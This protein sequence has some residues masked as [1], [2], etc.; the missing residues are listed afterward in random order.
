MAVGATGASAVNSFDLSKAETAKPWSVSVSLRGLYDSNPYNIPDGN[1]DKKDSF[2]LWVRPVLGLNLVKEEIFLGARYTYDA[3]Y[4]ERYS[5]T[6]QSHEIEGIV[7]YKPSERVRVSARD[8]FAYSQQPE[9]LQG[10][11]AQSTFARTD[12]SGFRNRAEFNGNVMFTR[13]SGMGFGYFGTIYDYDASGAPTAGFTPYSALLDRNENLFNVN[14]RQVIVPTWIGYLG[15]QYGFVDYTG[16][17]QIY[18]GGPKSDSRNYRSHYV[19]AGVDHDISSKLIASV[20]GGATYTS[21]PSYSQEDGWMPYGTVSL[22]YTYLPGCTAELG[23][24]NTMSA[25]DV[26]AASAPGPGGTTTPT[27]SQE[28]SSLYLSVEHR[29]TRDISAKL[30]SQMQ[31]ASFVG[32]AYAD[33]NENWLW[34]APSLEYRFEAGPIHCAVEGGYGYQTLASDAAGRDFSRHTVFLGFRA[35]Y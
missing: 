33:Q 14:F 2:G 25:T 8:S 10:S 11:G 12:A 7:D 9:V 13:E 31:F 16:N 3:R 19:Y 23:Y 20:R 5:E 22:K 26:A 35:S 18:V 27:L 15:Y 17:E 29:L 4:Y 32:G 21:Y 30:W 24:M 34:V 6:D 28:S 1:N